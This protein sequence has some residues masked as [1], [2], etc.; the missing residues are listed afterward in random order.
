MGRL[1]TLSRRQ[2]VLVGGAAVL[3]AAVAGTALT[4][5]FGAAL[6][7]VGP[8]NVQFASDIEFEPPFSLFKIALL[9]S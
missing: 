4:G 1:R 3:C 9:F 2:L 8:L 7:V 6:T 5:H